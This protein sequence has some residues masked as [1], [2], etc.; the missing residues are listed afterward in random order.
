MD[1]NMDPIGVFL[2]YA[3]VFAVVVGLRYAWDWWRK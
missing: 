1:Y 2:S 3:A